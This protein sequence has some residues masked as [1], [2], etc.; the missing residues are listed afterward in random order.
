GGD[1]LAVAWQGPD[2]PERTVID[3]SFLSPAPWNPVILKAKDPNPA[4][5]AV[6]VDSA[7]LEWG[8]GP[9]AVS[10][11]V[12]LSTD[13]VIDEVNDLV[14]ETELTIHIE[15][16]ELATTYYWRVD[17]VDADGTTHEG[18]LW[19]FTTIPLEAHFPSPLNLGT[20]IPLDAQ[21]SWSAGKDA[22]MHDVYFD[23]NEALVAAGDPSTFKGKLM[24]T[25]FDP[26]PLDPDTTYYWKVDE[27]ALGVTNPGP[28]WSFTTLDPEAAID[29]DPAD[30]AE[31]V[32]DSVTL[33][34]SAGE[35]AASH[36]VY[37]STDANALGDAVTVEEAAFT[38]AATLDWNTTY[39][40][41]VDVNTADGVMHP[42]HEVWS[43]KVADYL[44]IDDSQ[45]TLDYDNSADPFVSEAMWDTPADLTVNGVRNLS[46]QFQGALPPLPPEGSIS[47]DLDTGA[48]SITGSGADIWGNADQF[49]YGYRELTGDAVM[50][51]R[52]ADNGSG[53]NEWAKGG[54]MIRQSLDAGSTHR[55]MPITAGGGN[56]A[57]FQGRPVADAGSI[58]V[59]SGEVVAPPYWV[60][61]ERVGN[62]FSG[63]ISPDGVTWTQL[64][65]AE[66]VEMTDPVL[67]GLAVTSHAA[68][69]LRTMTFDNV[70]IVGDI[71]AD[72]MST[73]IGLGEVGNAPAPIYAALEDSTGA[74][75]MVVHPNPAA[76]NIESWKFEIPVTDF[77]GVDLTSV[78]KLYIGV[79]DG[80][81][82]GSGT[83]DIDDIRVT[84]PVVIMEPGDISMPGDNVKGVPDDGDW[85]GGE[86]PALAIDDDTGT[87][88]L[89]FKGFE[90]P[91]GIQVTPSAKQVVTGLTFTTAND[92]PERDPITFELYG[93][94]EGIDGTYELIAS[95]DIVDFNDPNT[96]W[97]RFT[98][99]ETPI[100]FDNDMVYDHYQVLF[101]A[102]RDAASANSMQ[103]AEIELITGIPYLNNGD[104][105]DGLDHDNSI[106]MWDGSAPGAGNPGGAAALTEDDVTYLRV[107]DTGDPRDYSSTVPTLKTNYS[108]YLTQSINNGLDGARLEFR[109]RIATS[110]TLDAWRKDGGGM[111]STGLFDWPSGGLGG[112]FDNYGRGN[113]DIAEKGQGVISFSLSTSGLM[114]GNSG[115]KA[116]VDDAT[117]WNTFVI[118]IAAYDNGKYTV[119][120]SVNGKLSE[121]FEVSAGS[122]VVEDGSYIAI[123][124]PDLA[125]RIA[126]AFDV[127]YISVT[128]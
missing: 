114:V 88:F 57:S 66:T 98:M 115:N 21:F 93:S 31:D 118:E 71:S 111:G 123:G 91:T 27:F 63:S 39:Y 5:G 12:Y 72:D 11:K 87:K 105:L 127:D 58:N 122:G 60:K 96:P 7:S 73:D 79:G 48:Y 120:V 97:P 4:D 92:S 69:E 104:T 22:I 35:T 128:K 23:V 19:S 101:P 13:D 52:V 61:L 90:L 25:S 99:N 33:S 83:I 117:Q 54:V 51:A 45:T 65:G 37:I 124:S 8:V 55:Y 108:L 3:G 112:S 70:D 29:P 30:G 84:K 81:P 113:I 110:G 89:H 16:L 18:N 102:V 85:P 107:Q 1:N 15:T 80:E 121:S 68:G 62:D 100:S 103:I 9:T 126:T 74:V 82:G 125:G 86:Y 20:W 75:A 94:N 34:W 50:I 2:S 41:S 78:A 49:H 116:S 59:D 32:A 38:P 77:D 119:S 17:E 44:I 40:W 67:I 47:L 46:F 36:D 56:G 10:H 76:T 53:T 28:V 95:G 109:A 6:D 43:F 42:A 24:V 106:D 14:A 64:G 26:G